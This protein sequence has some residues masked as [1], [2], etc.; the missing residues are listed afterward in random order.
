M[1]PVSGS[2]VLYVIVEQGIHVRGHLVIC[3]RPGQ[4]YSV[5]DYLASNR[6]IEFHG[7]VHIKAW[8]ADDCLFNVVETSLSLV[9]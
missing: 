7:L 8:K 6:Q 5:A 1:L 2:A 9:G 4:D 3:P